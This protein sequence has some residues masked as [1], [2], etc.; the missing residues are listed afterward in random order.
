M[1][2]V[3]RRRRMVGDDYSGLGCICWRRRNPNDVI[4]S[5]TLPHKCSPPPRTPPYPKAEHPDIQK[6]KTD[7]KKNKYKDPRPI[8]FI[9]PIRDQSGQQHLRTQ[10]KNMTH[11]N[12]TN[13]PFPQSLSEHQKHPNK[14]DMAVCRQL[15][16]LF[17][18]HIRPW[19]SCEES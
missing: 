8:Y 2:D 17:K 7:Q 13:S 1:Q 15:V 10:N 14:T 19:H 3:A 4:R 11:E 16:L 9:T 5:I 6:D 18:E 12:T